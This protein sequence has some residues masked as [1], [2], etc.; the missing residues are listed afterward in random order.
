MLL[1]GTL[2]QINKPNDAGGLVLKDSPPNK[3]MKQNILPITTKTKISG[4]CI[5][6]APVHPSHVNVLDPS[7]VLVHWV[8][9]DGYDLCIPLGK[10]W[11]QPGYLPEFS[12]ADRSEVSRVREE[13]PPAA[14]GGR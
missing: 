12:G 13:Y 5:Q 9:G 10:L 2:A 3:K 4:L 11:H 14:E 7:L 6:W 1:L 8:T